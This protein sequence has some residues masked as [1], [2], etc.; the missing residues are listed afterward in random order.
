M[1]IKEVEVSSRNRGIIVQ[2]NTCGGGS[3]NPELLQ[4]LDSTSPAAI[5]SARIVAE[6]HDT[7][8]PGHTI[9]IAIL[10]LFH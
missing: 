8:F 9:L 1:T 5:R 10:R 6:A 3:A 4:R 7:R 2:C